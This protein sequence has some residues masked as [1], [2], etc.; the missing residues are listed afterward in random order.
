MF[1]L[2]AKRQ[3]RMITDGKKTI[4]YKDGRVV[5]DTRLDRFGERNNLD[6]DHS[7]YLA[8]GMSL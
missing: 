2:Y 7:I 4:I 3:A 5:E 8:V 1:V 6:V